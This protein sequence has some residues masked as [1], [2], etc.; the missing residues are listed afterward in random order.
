MRKSH[1]QARAL[2]FIELDTG[3]YVPVNRALNADGYF[4]KTWKSEETGEKVS[5]MF[6]RFIFRAHHN[7]SEI[8]KG[9]ELDHLCGVRCCANVNH[10]R[11]V[12]RQTHLQDTNRDRYALRKSAAQMFWRWF[13][14]TGTQLAETFEVTI[15]TA[16]KWI[17]E[18]KA[19]AASV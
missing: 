19:G 7:L 18:W 14:C 6:H 17:R 15:S 1:R 8:P 9:Y 11:L 5:E 10:L 12:D 3:C 2:Q 4:R 16:C 13:D